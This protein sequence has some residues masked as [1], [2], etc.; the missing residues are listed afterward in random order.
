MRWKEAKK[1]KNVRMP[2][3]SHR[4]R[5]KQPKRLALEEQLRDALTLALA[6]KDDKNADDIY[7]KRKR[8]R[9]G[10]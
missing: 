1:S 2:F 6:P 5:P 10:D 4:V 3:S 8:I 7:R 9:V